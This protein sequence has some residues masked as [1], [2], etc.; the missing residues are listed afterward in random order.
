VDEG[1]RD[2]GVGGL[3][4]GRHASEVG[5]N[6]IAAIGRGMDDIE[7]GGSDNGERNQCA[8]VST[9]KRALIRMIPR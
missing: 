3:V 8:H 7:A 9:S 2:S 1:L 6:G 5:E 4:E